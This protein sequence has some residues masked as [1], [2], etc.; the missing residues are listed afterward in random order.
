MLGGGGIEYV[1]YIYKFCG[2]SYFRT[3]SIIEAKKSYGENMSSLY[4][5]I[6]HMQWQWQMHHYPH[7]FPKD[8]WSIS[9]GK[10][11]CEDKNLFDKIQNLTQN[12]DEVSKTKIYTIIARLKTCYLSQNHQIQN[13]TK[14][15]LDE[16]FE[17]QTKFIPNIFQVAENVFCYNGYFLP[18]NHF[19]VGMFWSKMGKHILSLQTLE[20]IKQKDII[21][22]GGYIGDSAIIFEK[23]WT[24]KNIYSFEA[25]KKNYE[26]ML[27]TIKLNQSTRI[28]PINKGLGSKREILKIK[29]QGSA[30]SIGNANEAD[31]ECEIITL[32][33]FVTQNNIEVGFIKVDIEGFEQEFLKGAMN[34]IKTQKPAMLISIYHNLDDFFNIK[35]LIESWNLGYKFKIYRP[36]ELWNFHVETALYCEVID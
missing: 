13:L 2:I 14:E 3:Q 11:L 21:D 28:N 5:E 35:P 25:T 30:S 31:E 22:V 16:F 7:L 27:Q 6:K 20:K 18:I 12:L 10:C 15:E 24:D 17:I 4:H 33:E 19:E 8:D 1:R 32:D 23:E 9:L 29:F 34:T 36:S 26:L